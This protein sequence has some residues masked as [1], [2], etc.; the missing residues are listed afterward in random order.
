MPD[1]LQFVSWSRRGAAVG[2]AAPAQPDGRL[3]VSRQFSVGSQPQGGASESTPAE[4]AKVSVLGPGDVVGIDLAQIVRRSP[5]TDDHNLEPNYLA[6]IEFAHPDLPWMFSPVLGS[7]E[8][9]QPWLM[10]VVLPDEQGDAVTQPIGKPCPVV[11][12]PSVAAVP[13]PTDAW[14]FAHVQV[15]GAADA[16]T[17]VSWVKALAAQASSVRSRL[18]CPTRLRPERAYRAVLVPVYEIGRLAGLDQ[19]VPDGTGTALWAPAAGL[20][21]PVYDTWRFWTGPSGDFETLAKKLHRIGPDAHDALGVRRVVVEAKASLLQPQGPEPDA[22]AGVYDVPTAITKIQPEQRGPLAPDS[23][24]PDPQAAELHA[25]L[26]QVVDLVAGASADDPLVGPPLYGQWPALVTSLDGTPGAPELG[27]VPA[28]LPQTWVEQLNADPSLRAASGLATRVVQHD[29][30]EL[31][32]DAWAQLEQVQ[33]ANTRIRWASMFAHTT[34]A[35]HDRVAALGGSAA[36]RLLAP[37]T[38]R[39][40]EQAD[41]TFQ[42]R[43]EAS[44]V[45]R[46]ALGAALARTARFAVKATARAADP[47]GASRLSTSAVV[48]GT[49]EALRTS[50]DGA[51]PARF[52]SARAIDPAILDG[53]TADADMSARLTE[54]LAADPVDYVAR[55]RDIPAAMERVAER[56]VVEPG[57][58]GQAVSD[59]TQIRLGPE[60]QQKLQAMTEMV[61]QAQAAGHVQLTPEVVR[62][63][64][65]IHQQGVDQSIPLTTISALNEAAG[66]VQLDQAHPFQQL[67]LDSD[68][69]EIHLDRRTADMSSLL[70][71]GLPAQQAQAAET[72]SAVRS[73]TL[74]NFGI[75]DV[76]LTPVLGEVTAEDSQRLTAMID[77]VQLDTRPSELPV[78]TPV[79]EQLDLAVAG[80]LVAKLEP[81]Q[82]YEQLLAFAFSDQGVVRRPSYQFHPAMA[83]PSF[84]KPAVERLKSLDEEWVLGGLRRLEPNSV[85]LLAVNWRFVESFLAGANHEIA[86]ELLWRGYPTDLRGTCF[87]RFWNGPDEDIRAMDHWAQPIGTHG[88]AGD[89]VEFTILLIKGDLLRRYPNTI[90]AAEK[91]TAA[92]DG[93]EVTFTSEEHHPELF[94]GFLGQDV[95]Y[96]AIDVP[97][98]VLGFTDPADA[99]HCWYISLSEPQNEPRFGLDDGDGDQPGANAARAD[100]DEWSWAGLAA[101]DAPHLG[102]DAVQALGSSSRVGSNLFQRPFRLLLRARDSVT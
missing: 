8:R 87:R 27:P 95:S 81:V 79:L 28:G 64:Q 56:V 75:A 26:K 13:D 45:P 11:T 14:A 89:R 22:F 48:S 9:A 41:S 25:R 84:P 42:A 32:A 102:P 54:R 44:T 90:I 66:R 72:V 67:H 97:P 51:I 31:M 21:L 33:A 24:T 68:A 16:P 57:Q 94:R 83:A 62:G 86:R 76:D 29:Q 52:T 58:P 1:N 65:L 39:L 98:A 73:A 35:L 47:A 74:S 59:A 18:L 85:C 19:P 15:H 12:V 60:A 88:V 17:A 43:L 92:K 5:R 93:E 20:Q 77:E 69:T 46:E 50:A 36:L 99:R 23:P 100:P 101:P 37:A 6:A 71:L 78:A 2:N 30:E 91:G 7:G 40:L 4:S 34:V 96:V 3:H 55:I 49:M 82:A 38:G 70:A 63:L 80:Q 10:L 61:S 53:I